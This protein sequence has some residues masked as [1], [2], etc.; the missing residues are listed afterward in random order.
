MK[1]FISEFNFNDYETYINKSFQSQYNNIFLM[2]MKNYFFNDNYSF[3][4]PLR[5]FTDL[6]AY[7]LKEVKSKKIYLDNLNFYSQAILNSHEDYNNIKQ[8]LKQLDIADS[9]EKF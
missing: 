7:S 2:F 1:S 9:F 4:T 3:K 6:H 8:F 5:T